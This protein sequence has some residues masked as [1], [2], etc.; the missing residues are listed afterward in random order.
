[1]LQPKYDMKEMR[2]SSGSGSGAWAGGRLRLT[3][4]HCGLIV[5]ERRMVRTNTV[6]ISGALACRSRLARKPGGHAAAAVQGSGMRQEHVHAVCNRT[7]TQT[8]GSA[9]ARWGRQPAA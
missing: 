1:M 8:A 2:S 3:R 6:L 5:S 7:N 9:D 4:F